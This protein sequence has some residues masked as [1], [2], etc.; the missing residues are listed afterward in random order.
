MFNIYMFVL[1]SH[2]G[3]VFA[4]IKIKGNSKFIG[5]K[6]EQRDKICISLLCFY[7]LYMI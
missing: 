6:V 1:K 2:L 4:M 3:G 5:N 7:C